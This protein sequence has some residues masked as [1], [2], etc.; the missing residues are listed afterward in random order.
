MR[1]SETGEFGLI[2]ALAEEVGVEY[3][4]RPGA[5]PRPGVLVDLGD[6]A[7]VTERRDVATVWTTD[8]L[9]AGVHFL[10]ERVAWT[11]VGWKALAV[12]LSDVAAMGATPDLSLITLALPPDFLVSDAAAL[13]RGLGEAAARYGVRIGGGDIVRSPTFSITVA[14]SGVADMPRLGQPRAMTRGAAGLGDVVAVSGTLGDSAGGLQLLKSGAPIDSDAARCLVGRHVRPEPRVELGQMAI[15]AGVRCAIDV[16]DGLVQDLGHVAR[17]S[18][19]GI[20][21]EMTRLPM[22][23]ELQERFRA[24]APGMAL[25]GGEDYELALVAPRAVIESLIDAGAGLTEVGEVVSYDGP[26]VAVVDET[27]REV[28]PGA[29]GWDH[30]GEAR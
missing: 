17:A 22:S 11:D 16:S 25:T 20:R 5:R 6:D 10:P 3:P 19:V 13:Y 2:A 18:G 24:E 28:D 29:G 8:T 21:V 7:V 23:I 12:N 27:G 14:L 30:F 15:R 4:P 9:V 26:R 1:V